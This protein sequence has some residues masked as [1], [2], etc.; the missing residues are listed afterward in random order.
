[1]STIGDRIKK[2]RK[3]LGLTQ[4]ELGEKLQVTDRA[5]S[6]WEQN[7]GNPDMSII[8]S[9]ADILGVSLDYLIMG[10]ETETIPL[11]DMDA[12]K[13]LSFLIKKDDLNNFKKFNYI[14]SAFIFG[15]EE[16]VYQNNGR[17]IIYPSINIKTW[18][19]IITSKA[20]KILKYCLDELLKK[21]KDEVW[22]TPVV[23]DFLDAFVMAMIDIDRDDVLKAMGAQFFAVEGYGGYENGQLRVRQKPTLVSP[24][25]S[26]ND[27]QAYVIKKETWEYFFKKRQ[28]S[29]RSFSLIVNPVIKG[30]ALYKKQMGYNKEEYLV[31]FSHNALLE[32]ALK[33]EMYD[34]IRDFKELA[35]Q[36]FEHSKTV[37]DRY[38]LN[39]HNSF[40]CENVHIIGRLFSFSVKMIEELLL[41][42][43]ISLAK[44]LNAYNEKVV[45]LVKNNNTLKGTDL[46]NLEVLSEAEI[47][48]FLKLHDNS[49]SENERI[50]IQCIK[51]D[52]ILVVGQALNVRN[53]DLLRKILKKSYYNPF[54]IACECYKQANYKKIFQYLL[55]A[56]LQE[57]AKV[58]LSGKEDAKIRTIK[59]LY[60]VLA[61]LPNKLDEK[62][63]KA[64]EHE[65]TQKEYLAGLNMQIAEDEDRFNTEVSKYCIEKMYDKILSLKEEIYSK[66]K[67]TLDDQEKK[68]QL[69]V[70][71]AKAKKG[72]TLDYFEG[73]LESLDTKNRKLFI[74]DLCS[75]FDAILK[76]DYNCEGEDFFGRMNYYHDKYEPKTQ[77]CDDGWGYSVED[78]KHKETVILPWQKKWG[79]VSRLRMERNNIAH[80]EHNEVKE[81]SAEELKECLEFIFSIN[82]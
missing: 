43:Q 26:Y 36:E 44:E 81:L 73:L 4:A 62:E 14:Q 35:N 39:Y 22:I 50:E 42:K 13:R 59:N 46:K 18:D 57:Y 7:E 45:Q 63:M 19:E 31:T 69:A 6:K 3:E 82:K 29:P 51:D 65:S 48:R 66:V 68:W 24:S 38:Q 54:E 55:N 30:V 75:L 56:N 33:Y 47:E 52:G 61:K 8:A 21:I 16:T 78:T 9:L 2:R 25:D 49:I 71:C 23:A 74:I 72:L 77:Y 20:N 10:K 64:I 41:K 17:S 11:E 40:I 70:E 76:Y 67:Q 58:F 80:A 37:L 34:V 79:L 1:M 15:K 5:V 32:Y 28:E 27:R 53:L 60:S 12:Q